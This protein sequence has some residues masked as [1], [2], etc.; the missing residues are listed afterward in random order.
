MYKILTSPVN[1]KVL[2]TALLNDES[3]YWSY[4]KDKNYFEKD[5]F[6]RIMFGKP[7]SYPV[8]LT[9]HFRASFNRFCDHEVYGEYIY[10]RSFGYGNI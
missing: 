3:D 2:E 10:L 8:I 6:K 4:I 9:T 7:K 1:D 5:G